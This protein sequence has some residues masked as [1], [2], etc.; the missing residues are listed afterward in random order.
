MELVDWPLFMVDLPL[1]LGRDCSKGLPLDKM[2]GFARSPWR[3]PQDRAGIRGFSYS[4]RR[5]WWADPSDRWQVI[6]GEG[7]C[8]NTSPENWWEQS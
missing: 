1:F 5:A 2:T 6:C 7:W 4:G 3:G 8:V